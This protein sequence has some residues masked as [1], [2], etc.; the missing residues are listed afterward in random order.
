MPGFDFVETPKAVNTQLKTTNAVTVAIDND[1]ADR[2]RV[3]MKFPS[4][5]NI[6]KKTGDTNGTSVQFKFQLANGNGSF[7]DVIAAGESS[8]DVTLTAK[9]LVSTTAVTKSSF[10]AR[11]CL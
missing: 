5:R 11:A 9:R 4:L 8:S 3:I 7:Y 6:D 2:V 10:K 1:D